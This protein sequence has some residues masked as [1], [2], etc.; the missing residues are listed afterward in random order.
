MRGSNS[1][2][3]FEPQKCFHRI[4]H[5]PF[6]HSHRPTKTHL[7]LFVHRT[8]LLIMMHSIA[9]LAS[10]SVLS[11]RVLVTAA[12]IPTIQ[13]FSTSS[14]FSS[15]LDREILEETETNPIQMPEDLTELKNILSEKWTIV[16]GSTTG[17]DGATVR[18]YKKEPLSNGSKVFLKF[19]CQDTEQE[20]E[21]G[22]FEDE[23]PEEISAPLQF[24]VQVSRAGKTMT[25][26]C[27]SEDA[28]ASVEG[29]IISPSS[30]AAAA[31]SKSEEEDLYRGPILED[32]PEDVKEEFD[33]YLRKEC[34]VDEDVAAF[35]AM[36]ADYREQAEYIRWLKE[37][38]KIV[39]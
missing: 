32:L 36:Y 10:R 25:M 2:R 24:E 15:L 20:E 23:E 31:A 5:H 30:D 3:R 28:L 19:H 1:K 22:L 8:V 21:S 13:T 33:L 35:T 34:E 7:I 29:I 14:N 38:Q 9:K 11:K 39:K 6:N 18:M 37:V 17:E 16:D 12:R 26:T 4:I 27:T